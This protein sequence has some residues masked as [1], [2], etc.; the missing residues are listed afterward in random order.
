MKRP[1]AI[2]FSLCVAAPVG[3]HPHIFIDTGLKL[4]FDADGVLETVET[5]WVYDPLYSLLVTEDMQLDPDFDGVLTPDEVARLTGFDMQWV[6]GFNGDL[7]V[8]QDDRHLNLSGPVSYAASFADGRITTTHVRN[9]MDAQ[10]GVPFH[11][12][13]YDP[14]YYTAYDVTLPV[15]VTGPESCRSRIEMPDLSSGLGAVRLQLMAL[16]PEVDPADVGFEDIGAEFATTVIA[17]CAP[18]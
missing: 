15:T 12:K 14:T 10:A 7:V 18:S 13:P 9:V 17:T 3:A 4:T 11:L 5:T 8:L 6:E 2:L 1:A 16:D